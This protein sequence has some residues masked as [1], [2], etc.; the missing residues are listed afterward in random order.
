VT[1]Y[2][3]KDAEPEM[4]L[5]AVRAGARRKTFIDPSVAGLLGE[6]SDDLTARELDVLCQLA[7]GR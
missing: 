7:L 1:G 6:S 3:R 2:I 4:L 5:A